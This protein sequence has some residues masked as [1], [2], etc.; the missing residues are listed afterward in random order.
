MIS[1]AVCLMLLGSCSTAVAPRPVP[2]SQLGER[3]RWETARYGLFVHHVYGGTLQGMTPKSGSGGFPANI[4]QFVESF[5]VDRFANAAK[6][7]GF[8]YV[9]FT[10]WHFNM[11][12]LYPSQRMAKWRDP[13]HATSKRDLLG[14]IIAALRKRGIMAA[15]YSHTFVGHEFRPDAQKPYYSYDRKDGVVTDEM[16]KTGYY[17]AASA[18]WGPQ[19]P[20]AE[21]KLWND[22]INDIYDEMAARYGS[23]VE[24]MYF[25]GS[26]VWMVDRQRLFNTI[27]RHNPDAA[28]IANG[29]A[30][31]GYEYSS[32]EIG[33]PEGKDY[34]FGKDAIGVTNKDARTWPGYRRHVALIAGA[35]WWAAAPGGPKFS[36]D[37]IVRYTIL[38][39]ASSAAGGIGWSFG[40]Y[41]NGTFE[42]GLEDRFR[43]VWQKLKPIQASIRNVVQSRAYPTP[44]KTTINSLPVPF[45]ATEDKSGRRTYLHVLKPSNSQTLDIPA[46]GASI[47]FARASVLGT[48]GKVSLAPKGTGWELKFDGK[49]DPIDTVIVL[50]HAR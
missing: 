31:H 46:A 35:N 49:W 33:S 18:P 27:R 30:E 13:G 7:M 44:E 34:G 40:T 37:D 19:P 23:R 22:F 48:Q 1:S 6:D 4:D 39:A 5:D 47:K 20:P 12:V 24:A 32:N 26:W 45:V 41:A 14:E 9:I 3:K 17:P 25:D 2:P 43:E 11:N 21:T 10:A 36:V 50:E 8:E 28:L 15:L 38:Q 29:T 16:R 42:T